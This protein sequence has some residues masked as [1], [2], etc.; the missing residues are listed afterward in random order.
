MVVWVVMMGVLLAE[1]LV[2]VSGLVMAPGE[3]SLAEALVSRRLAK[4]SA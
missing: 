4:K 1:A 2:S 3:A